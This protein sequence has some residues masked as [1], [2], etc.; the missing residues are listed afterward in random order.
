MTKVLI[1]ILTAA[2]VNSQAATVLETEFGPVSEEQQRAISD[3]EKM[4]EQIAAEDFQWLFEKLMPENLRR[5]NPDETFKSFRVHLK[6]TYN[7]FPDPDL[8]LKKNLN[9]YLQAT[10]LTGSITYA[11]FFKKPY[12]MTLTTV[13]DI[14]NIEVRVH[15]KNPTPQDKIDFS[16]KVKI[17]E[18]LWNSSQVVTDFKYNF[19]FKIVDQAKLAHYSVTVKDETRGPYDTNWGRDWTGNTI[20]H[21]IGHMLGLG[22]EYQTISGQFDCLRSSLMCSAWYGAHMKH[23]YYFVLRRFVKN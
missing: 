11:G 1:F 2:I 3:Q 4:D 21:E 22:D 19:I 20:A 16:Q 7:K 5:D 8:I 23:H 10:E 14:L 9:T 6:D 13:N 17:A 18:S 12:R 15:L